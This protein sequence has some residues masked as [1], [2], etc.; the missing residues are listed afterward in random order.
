MK[1]LGNIQEALNWHHAGAGSGQFQEMSQVR[2]QKWFV[3]V[4]PLWG[5][6]W[7]VQETT[8]D[9]KKIEYLVQQDIC[10]L[11]CTPSGYVLVNLFP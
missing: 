1:V 3:D 9:S 11:T 5:D 6:L 10:V 2:N 8:H 4:I 7:R